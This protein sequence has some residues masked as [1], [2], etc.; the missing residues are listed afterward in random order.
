MVG[1]VSVTSQPVQPKAKPNST[2]VPKRDL[3]VFIPVVTVVD[4]SLSSYTI[5]LM[6]FICN[7]TIFISQRF[8]INVLPI[9]S[10]S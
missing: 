9:R 3:L 10:F 2:R 6:G 8:L 5:N 1:V 7:Q 4:K